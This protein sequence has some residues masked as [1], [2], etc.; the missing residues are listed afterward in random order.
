V[1]GPSL[2][3]LPD[4]SQHSQETDISPAGYEAALP[5]SERPQTH[6]LDRAA[7]W[8]GPLLFYVHEIYFMTV[9]FEDT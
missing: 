6:A 5:E 3:P 2:R 1:I 8:I 9:Q 4:N 7:S